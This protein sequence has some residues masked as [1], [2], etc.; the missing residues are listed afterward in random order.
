MNL[1]HSWEFSRETALFILV[2]MPLEKYS[3][4]LKELLEVNSPYKEIRIISY[5]SQAI[6]RM[7]LSKSSYHITDSLINL[8]QNPHKNTGMITNYLSYLP[9]KLFYKRIRNFR[10]HFFGLFN[11]LGHLPLIL[12]LFCLFVNMVV[13]SRI[14]PQLVRYFFEVQRGLLV[15]S[16]LF[17]ATG[18][19]LA[20]MLDTPYQR[21][22]FYLKQLVP[23]NS[24]EFIQD[25]TSRWLALGILSVFILSGVVLCCFLN[26]LGIFGGF[27]LGIFAFFSHT[28]AWY[29]KYPLRILMILLLSFVIQIRTLLTIF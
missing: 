19:N 4:G 17:M 8:I 22:R 2:P 7:H 14:S 16:Y 15:G 12:P 24:Q 28:W 27:L 1:L 29:F 18:D 20:S 25:Y 13:V 9:L 3:L 21:R 5:D 26:P 6:Y 11:I 10:V 23:T